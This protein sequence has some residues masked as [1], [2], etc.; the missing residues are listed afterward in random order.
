MNISHSKSIITPEIPPADD[1]PSV[2]IFTGICTVMYFPI[3]FTANRAQIPCNAV[4]INAKKNFFDL[5]FVIKIIINYTANKMPRKILP[6]FIIF[7]LNFYGH[8]IFIILML[9]LFLLT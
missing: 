2:Q 3:K 9:K 8:I 1:I 6:E 4:N 5:K 7:L